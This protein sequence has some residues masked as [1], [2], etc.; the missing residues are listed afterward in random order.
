M[1]HPAP[2]LSPASI[3]HLNQAIN[4]LQHATL[5]ATSTPQPSSSTT[6]W[7]PHHQPC[8]MHPSS[9]WIR[10]S[11]GW[12]HPQLMHLRHVTTAHNCL[13]LPLPQARWAMPQRSCASTVTICR[14]PLDRSNRCGI[15]PL[16]PHIITSVRRCLLSSLPL[17]WQIWLPSAWRTS[18]KP[19]RHH[20]G[21]R[22][23]LRENDEWVRG[24]TQTFHWW[25]SNFIKKALP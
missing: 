22:V 16:P 25:N 6:C 20:P 8:Q 4:G 2:F 23:A 10:F 19:C 14:S 7:I 18:E 17:P 24:R 3:L 13:Q 1:P 5:V 21:T 9:W 15:A 11:L 12:I